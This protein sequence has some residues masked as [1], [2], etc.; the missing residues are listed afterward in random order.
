MP[1]TFPVAGNR[2]GRQDQV[3]ILV[4]LISQQEDRQCINMCTTF[5]QVVSVQKIKEVG[6][7]LRGHRGVILSRMIKRKFLE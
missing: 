1:G 6:T 4:E 7:E 3:V 5:Y 2:A